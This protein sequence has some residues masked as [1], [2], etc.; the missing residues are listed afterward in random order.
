MNGQLLL[1]GWGLTHGSF[2]WNVIHNLCHLCQ[3]TGDSRIS[4]TGNPHLHKSNLYLLWEGTRSEHGGQF[5]YRGLLKILSVGKDR[6]PILWCDCAKDAPTLFQHLVTRMFSVLYTR[7]REKNKKN[8][9]KLWSFLGPFHWLPGAR[10]HPPD[11]R[12]RKQCEGLRAFPKPS[13]SETR[14]GCY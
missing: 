6:A 5:V 7:L 12:I 10:W 14:Y 8:K 2:S 3:R 4:A 9:G 13:K 1:S 11:L